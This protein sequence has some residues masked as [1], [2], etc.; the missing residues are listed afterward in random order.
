VRPGYLKIDARN[1]IYRLYHA[2]DVSLSLNSWKLCNVTSK[3]MN[4]K[5]MEMQNDGNSRRFDKQ[6]ISAI[7]SEKE[8]HFKPFFKS[9]CFLIRSGYI[10]KL[11]AEFHLPQKDYLNITIEHKR[12]N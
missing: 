11:W 5:L 3:K 7:K 1:K 2:E 8:P 9:Y 10:P 4:M 6:I 12:L